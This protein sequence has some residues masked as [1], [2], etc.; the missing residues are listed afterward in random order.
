MTPSLHPPKA[1]YHQ[2]HL[3]CCISSPLS[4]HCVSAQTFGHFTLQFAPEKKASLESYIVIFLDLG[5][6]LDNLGMSALFYV[7]TLFKKSPITQIR[8]VLVNAG[9]VLIED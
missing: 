1:E 5:E 7:L 6:I 3:S 8:D 9:P 4:H 2:I